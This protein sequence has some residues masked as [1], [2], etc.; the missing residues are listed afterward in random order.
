MSINPCMTEIYRLTQMA[1]MGGFYLAGIFKCEEILC[2]SYRAMTLLPSLQHV[3]MHTKSLTLTAS[4]ISQGG[5]HKYDISV[6][7]IQ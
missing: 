1:E 3:Q 4:S 2:Y 6:S 7:Q 5:Y